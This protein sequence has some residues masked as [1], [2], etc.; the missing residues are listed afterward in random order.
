MKP[1]VIDVLRRFLPDYLKNTSYLSEE[2]RRAIWAITNCRTP[3]MGGHVYRCEQCQKWEF[4]AHSCNHRSCPQCGSTAT[5][6]WVEREL[7]KRVGSHYYMVTFTLPAEFR[8]L[9]FG[10]NAKAAYDLFFQASSK[11]LREKLS[12]EKD[13]KAKVNG[14]TGILH[15]WNQR[16]LFHPH[17]HYIVPGSGIDADNNVVSTKYEN[18]LVNVH[19][20]KGA[21]RQYMR[22]GLEA[23]GWQ[24]DPKALTHNWG[25]VIKPFGNGVNVIKYLGAY[26]CK[27]AIGNKRIIKINE[28]KG[29]VT[30]RWKDRSNP[31]KIVTR[32]DT[33]DGVEFVNRYLRH[34]LPKGLRSIRYYG[35]CHPSAKKNRERIAFHTGL[36]LQ[37]GNSSNDTKEQEPTDVAQPPGVPLCPSCQCP[38]KRVAS[39][40]PQLPPNRPQKHPISRKPAP[41]KVH[42]PPH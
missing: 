21:F 4:A 35:F 42:P 31:N 22:E 30:F 39:F 8:S 20:L 26:V 34:V 9:F 11:A 1:K 37:C 17:I 23:L 10:V 36:P 40:P 24:I 27:T 18:Y 5:A 3:T 29:T 25:V 2:R 13:L 19:R 33:I 15:T 16:L 14:F 28:A 32:I 6:Q 38:M 12:E 41:V 7:N